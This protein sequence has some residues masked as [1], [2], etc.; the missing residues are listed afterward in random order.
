[1]PVHYTM[2]TPAARHSPGPGA[3][4]SQPNSLSYAQAH[5][6]H[7]QALRNTA[8]QQA[9]SPTPLI[10]P[11][12]P[13]SVGQNHPP[14]LSPVRGSEGRAPSPNYFGLI[15]DPTAESRDS[16]GPARDNWSPSSSVKSFAAALPKQVTLDANPDF[17]AFKR[18]ADMNRG[19]SIA[20]STAHYAPAPTSNPSLARPRPTRWHTHTS[21]T[22][23]EA[24]FGPPSA[25]LKER[26][27]QGCSLQVHP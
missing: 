1:M 22:G 21:D 16:S 14:K 4:G 5:A 19:K 11:R 7:I 24:H 10:S 2:K 13:Y 17:E 6:A 26:P 12:G 15:V 20:L 23:S 8:K 18:Q 9:K 25:S 3:G 27:A